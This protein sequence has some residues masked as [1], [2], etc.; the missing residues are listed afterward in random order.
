MDQAT[1]RQCEPNTDLGTL[2][3]LI[4]RSPIR[5]R[6]SES[7]LP[8]GFDAIDIA[9]LDWIAAQARASRHAYAQM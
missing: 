8:A 3:A 9:V 2:V 5:V 4:E 6:A 1:P 7:R